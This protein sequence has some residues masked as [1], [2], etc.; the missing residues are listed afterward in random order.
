[1]AYKEKPG[2]QFSAD[3]VIQRSIIGESSTY[4]EVVDKKRASQ[5]SK[6]SETPIPRTKRNTTGMK[7]TGAKFGLKQDNTLPA[8]VR[9]KKQETDL[10]TPKPI[11]NEDGFDLIQP[12]D[13]HTLK[14]SLKHASK[15]EN[16]DLVQ[17]V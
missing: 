1:M 8:L 6:E 5:T 13:A 17:K 7:S 2:L 9:K 3:K 15:L 10:P 11:E 14:K 12:P 16:V 4:Q